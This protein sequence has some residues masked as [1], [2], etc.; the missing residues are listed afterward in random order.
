MAKK[1]ATKKAA[2]SF[3]HVTAAENIESIL[4]EGLKGTTTPR[5]RGEE[6][7]TPSIC[8]LD[9][10]D[11]RLTDSIAIRQIWPAQD[12]EQYAVIQIS[13]AGVTGAVIGD[14][15][16]EHT[17]PWQWVIKQ[18]LIEPK[19]LKHLR[20]K[21]FNFP[22]KVAFSVLHNL[23]GEK[24]WTPIE[25]EIAEQYIDREKTAQRRVFEAQQEK[26][27][28]TAE[29]WKQVRPFV[30]PSVVEDQEAF[31]AKLDRKEIRKATVKQVRATKKPTKKK[32]AK[33]K[34]ARKQAK[35]KR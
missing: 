4:A 12:I 26:R 10:E 19:Y 3:Y 5:N 6:F 27:K 28:L 23:T 16:A 8:V 25:W 13:M 11:E 20:T 22:G 14:D 33:K 35:R 7:D 24:K 18:E 15:V 30:H 9:S 31:E 21:V 1:R 34:V 2:K 29:E 17:A 32:M